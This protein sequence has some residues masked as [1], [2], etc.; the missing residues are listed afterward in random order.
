MT[1]LIEM[2]TL[3]VAEAR[4]MGA[5]SRLEPPSVA[6][7]KVGTDELGGESLLALSDAGQDAAERFEIHSVTG[8]DLP[9]PDITQ[10]TAFCAH[11]CMGTMRRHGC[12]G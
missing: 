10:E 3:L 6:K 9:R 1:A 5:Q 8:S 7:S 4:E 11:N 12:S 2:G